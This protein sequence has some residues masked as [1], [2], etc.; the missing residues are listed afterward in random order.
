MVHLKEYTSLLLLMTNREGGRMKIAVFTDTFIPQY[1]GI[2]T[3]T[4]SLIKGLADRGN[5]VIVI[6]PKFKGNKEFKYNNVE[7]IRVGSIPALFYPEFRLASPISF[8]IFKLFK[9]E[10]VDVVLFQ[11]TLPL[12]LSAILYSKIF[13]RPLIGTFHTLVTH[14]DYLKHIKINYRFFTRFGWF[15]CKLFYNRANLITSPSSVIK[16]QLINERFKPRIK[17]VSNGIRL[18]IF[19]N[20]KSK[21]IKNRY[22]RNGPILLFVGRIAHEKNLHYLIDCFELIKDK[23]KKV[24]LL[25]VGDGPQLSNLK[26]Y[27]NKKN[28]R[29]SI[30][31]TGRLDHAKLVKTGIFGACDLFV[32]ASTT[33]TQGIST[34]EAQANGLVCVGVDEGG[35]K[36]LIRNNYNG[37]LVKNGDKSAFAN[38]VLTLLSNKKAYNKMKANTLKEVKKHEMKNVLDEWEKEFKILTK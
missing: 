9:K 4:I 34:L 38:S 16:K 19:D 22:N 6:A 13:R 26:E 28:L 27:A 35:I 18:D 37:F 17:T 7:V 2:V 25:I 24:K 36:D 30:I 31:F 15:Y 12:G 33:E 5:K 21:E 23:N 32:T 10:K 3:A 1:N 8:K 29:D 11:A 14:E 20:S